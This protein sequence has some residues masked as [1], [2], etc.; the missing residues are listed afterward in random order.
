MAERTLEAVVSGPDSK[1]QWHWRP[2]DGAGGT[3]PLQSDLVSP[4]WESG[5]IVELRLKRNTGIWQV[6][7]IAGPAIE[8]EALLLL[9]GEP[10]EFGPDDRLHPGTVVIAEIPFGNPGDGSDPNRTSKRRPAVVASVGDGF[11]SVRAVYSRN[12]EGR[13]TR[14]LDPEA[15][16]LKRGAVIAHDETP[17]ALP[18]VGRPF[19]VLTETDSRRLGI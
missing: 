1:G 4:L 15:A 13:G 8:P 14:L 3:Q 7:E 5:E 18:E 16:G 6:V 2:L 9:N 12:T 17:V 19:G 11:V 10:V